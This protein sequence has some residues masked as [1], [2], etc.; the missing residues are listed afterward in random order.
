[1][2]SAGSPVRLTGAIRGVARSFNR[3]NLLGFPVP[4]N[5]SDKPP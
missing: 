5:V 3:G 4:V 1:V 2:E